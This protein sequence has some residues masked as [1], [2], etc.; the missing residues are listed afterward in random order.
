MDILLVI[1][2]IFKTNVHGIPLWNCYV[3]SFSSYVDPL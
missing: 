2:G 3:T 1:D